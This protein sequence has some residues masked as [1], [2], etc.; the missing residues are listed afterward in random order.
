MELY[1]FIKKLILFNNNFN[2]LNLKYNR[3]TYISEFIAYYKL[4]TFNNFINIIELL[5]IYIN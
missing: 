4:N 5:T 1:F 2:K 3:F